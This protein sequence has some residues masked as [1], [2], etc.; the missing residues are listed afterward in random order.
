MGEEPQISH[1]Y[2]PG[3]SEPDKVPTSEKTAEDQGNQS[4]KANQMK[5]S[6]RRSTGLFPTPRSYHTERESRKNDLHIHSSSPEGLS[7]KAF[8]PP[9]SLP[10]GFDVP[11]QTFSDGSVS[12]KKISQEIPNQTIAF[13]QKPNLSTH[14]TGQVRG[15]AS[16]AVNKGLRFAQKVNPL[17]TQPEFVTYDL[18][19]YGMITYRVMTAVRTKRIIRSKMCTLQ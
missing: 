4:V 17:S 1:F 9:S 18:L 10:G 5:T 6:S 2:P 12:P 16:L 11:T 15:L 7:A 8:Y 13:D 3:Y 19:A 14:E